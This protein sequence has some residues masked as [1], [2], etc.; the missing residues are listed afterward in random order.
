MKSYPKSL[1][2]KYS[3]SLLQFLNSYL[4]INFQFFKKKKE[5]AITNE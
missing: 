5:T 1:R 4:P 3:A 2:Q